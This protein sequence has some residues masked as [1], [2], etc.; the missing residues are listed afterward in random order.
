[1]PFLRELSSHLAGFKARLRQRRQFGDVLQVE[2]A[3][4]VVVDAATEQGRVG[5]LAHSAQVHDEE[6]ARLLRAAQDPASEGGRNITP[7]EAAPI[8]RCVNRSA[9]KD[10]AISEA[11]A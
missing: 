11:L 9:E 1:M 4:D 6:A 3:E 7:R 5:Q 10:R 8:F 2:V